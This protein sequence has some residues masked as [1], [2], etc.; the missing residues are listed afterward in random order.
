MP[1]YNTPK[2]SPREA[3]ESVRN[4]IYDNWQLCI[5]D[6][7]STMPHVRKILAEY[8]SRDSRIKVLYRTRNGHI[9]EATNSVFELADGEWIAL[10]D[11]DDV[12]RP[13][14]LAEMALE[15]GRHPEA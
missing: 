14:A 12:L 8:A 2:R 13:H 3:I 9:S 10:L 15:I 6:D 4:Q 11:H 7:F 1:V 5:A